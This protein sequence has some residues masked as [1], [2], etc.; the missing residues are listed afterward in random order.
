MQCGRAAFAQ[1]NFRQSSA[2][3]ARCVHAGTWEHTEQCNRANGV[4]P[5]PDPDPEPD[6]AAEDPTA[7]PKRPRRPVSGET[8]NAPR[9]MRGRTIG[10]GVPVRTASGGVSYSLR[11]FCCTRNCSRLT[12]PPVG[13]EPT[14]C[15][16]TCLESDGRRHAPDCEN[17]AVESVASL[18]IPEARPPPFQFLPPPAPA[19]APPPAPS[20]TPMPSTDRSVP[21]R[22]RTYDDDD[23]TESTVARAG[24]VYSGDENDEAS[25]QARADQNATAHETWLDGDKSLADDPDAELVDI[26]GD[27]SDAGVADGNSGAWEEVIDGDGDSD[28]SGGSSDV[29]DEVVENYDVEVVGGVDAGRRFSALAPTPSSPPPSLPLSTWHEFTSRTTGRSFYF[30]LTTRES[31]Y[32]K[33]AEFRGPTSEAD[34]AVVP[35][36]AP[37]PTPTPAPPPVQSGRLRR[38]RA[39]RRDWHADANR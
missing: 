31:V 28:V 13:T 5:D 23:D 37:A 17:S 36:P 18:A 21:G 26:A 6:D 20:P 38:P 39:T 11:V 24:S 19:P 3:C 22:P 8:P 15:C 25:Q 9:S 35:T 29:H 2:C 27:H 16:G 14:Y 12:A 32:A 34:V 10:L 7:V 4:H 33:P 1:E 30:N